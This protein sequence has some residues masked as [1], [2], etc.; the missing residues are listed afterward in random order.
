MVLL[1]RVHGVFD[2]QDGGVSTGNGGLVKQFGFHRVD[3]KPGTGDFSWD[4]ALEDE[5]VEGV[6]GTLGHVGGLRHGVS[7]L[8]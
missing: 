6:F 7:V 8:A 4:V 3:Q 1:R 5:G 2:V